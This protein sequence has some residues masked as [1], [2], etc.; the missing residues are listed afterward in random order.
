MKDNC[1]AEG[2]L[3]AAHLA[4][5][6]ILGRLHP[7]CARLLLPLRWLQAMHAVTRLVQELTP[8]SDTGTT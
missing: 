3:S 1:D 6:G 2:L 7:S 5:A 8:P 4:D